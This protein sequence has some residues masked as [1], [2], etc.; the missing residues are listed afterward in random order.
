MCLAQFFKWTDNII[1]EY[2][3]FLIEIINKTLILMTIISAIPPYEWCGLLR[4]VVIT[5]Q[6][7]TLITFFWRATH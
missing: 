2:N 3:E 4:R 6:K 1:S 5:S 7:Y